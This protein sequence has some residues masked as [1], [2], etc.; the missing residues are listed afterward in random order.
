MTLTFL[1]QVF[2]IIAATLFIAD[3]FLALAAEIK[4]RRRHSRIIGGMKP[5]SEQYG[6]ARDL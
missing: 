6:Q 4:R 1:F 3:F 5:T 2:A